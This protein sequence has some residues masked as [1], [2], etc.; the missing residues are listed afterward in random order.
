MDAKL[1]KFF[2]YDEIT[3]QI[4]NILMNNIEKKVENIYQDLD[5]NFLKKIKEKEKKDCTKIANWL[6]S[7]EKQ[8]FIDSPKSEDIQKY[9]NFRFNIINEEAYNYMNKTQYKLLSD[10]KILHPQNKLHT[11]VNNNTIFIFF[12]FYS[13]LLVLGHN[14]YFY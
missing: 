13:P 5:S 1:T 8:N 14:L 2:L 10:L 6:S 9:Y 7:F 3:K 11:I 4:I 12:I